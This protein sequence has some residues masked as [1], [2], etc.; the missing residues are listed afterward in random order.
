MSHSVPIKTEFK[1]MK[2][3]RKAF[4]DLGWSFKEN[5][6]MTNTY[7]SDPSRN[8]VFELV[9]INSLRG[10][11]DVGIVQNER[12]EI[13][14]EC[15]FFSAGKIAQTLGSEFSEL[16]KKYVLN[17]TQE[18]FEQVEIEQMFADGSFI[19]IADDGL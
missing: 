19:I 3:M 10:G 7:S 6:K 12:G 2:A 1:S 17:V 14:L 8:K 4:E 9:A 18:N 5:C 15:D 11:Y 16:K 13:T